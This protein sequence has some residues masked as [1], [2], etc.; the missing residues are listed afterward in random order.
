M[1]FVNT[2]TFAKNNYHD[3]SDSEAN[4]E[5]HLDF[6]DALDQEIEK[7]PLTEQ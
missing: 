3:E 6:L 2:E 1:K 7:N 5:F 4:T